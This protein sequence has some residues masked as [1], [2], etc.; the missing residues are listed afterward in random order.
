MYCH[1]KG[2]DGRGISLEKRITCCISY[3]RSNTLGLFSTPSQVQYDVHITAQNHTLTLD[4]KV[5]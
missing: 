1:G 4:R 2:R 3:D 5:I